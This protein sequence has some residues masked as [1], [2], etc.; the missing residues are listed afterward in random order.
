MTITTVSNYLNHH[1]IPLSNALYEHLG[2]DYHFIQTEPME[3]ERVKMGWGAALVSC[4]YLVHFYE[5]EARC[6]QMIME[7]DIVIFGGVDDES[8]I[9][10]RLKAGKIVIRSSERLYKDGQWKAITPRGLIKKYQDHTRYRNSQVYLLCDGGYVASDFHIV[11]AYPNK[12][13]CW[14]YFPCVKE[15]DLDALFVDKN[16]KIPELLWTGRFVG[17]K[18]PEY[19]PE[20]AKRLKKD[21]IQAHITY[22]GGGEMETQVLPLI[23]TEGLQSLITYLPF[24]SPDVIRTYMERANIYLFPSDYGEGWGAVLNEA[25]NSGCAVVANQAAG[26]TPYLCKD[27]E[28]ALIY[29]NGDFEEFYRCVVRL[30]QNEALQQKLG[31]N[32]YRTM[33]EMWN[34]P[35]AAKRLLTQ[36]ERMVAGEEIT[37][38]TEGPMSMAPIIAPGKMYRQ[39]K[40]HQNEKSDNKNFS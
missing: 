16:H 17:F 9:V 27:E 35:N 18:H 21:K 10:E 7:S 37:F 39:L 3:E 1:Q 12:M 31:R 29:K 15:Y 14:G 32:A 34:A 11:R 38:E 13:F 25:M 20:L 5:Q 33:I 30:I 8:Y 6:K 24:Q 19:I 36:C 23:E 26:A 2:D 22:I 4:P 40:L 28:N